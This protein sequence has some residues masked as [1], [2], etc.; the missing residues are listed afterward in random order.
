[1]NIL[2]KKLEVPWLWCEEDQIPSVID[3]I[4]RFFARLCEEL[5]R[6]LT[7][8]KTLNPFTL[9]CLTVCCKLFPSFWSNKE[10]WK[11]DKFQFIITDD[12]HMVCSQNLWKFYS[13]N[14]KKIIKPGVL[15]IIDTE[16]VLNVVFCQ[17]ISF[18]YLYF[19]MLHTN[20]H[21]LYK[22]KNK[23]INFFIE[24]SPISVHQFN[25]RIKHCQLLRLWNF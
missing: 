13:L 1:M 20:L 22:K 3:D 21:R 6:K 24:S 12:R 5:C 17:S 23:W 4:W 9:Q 7:R 10:D 16:S 11:P 18:F 25:D 8:L 2:T 14:C 19:S 15:C